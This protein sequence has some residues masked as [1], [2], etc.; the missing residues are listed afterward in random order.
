MKVL[1]VIAFALLATAT[2]LAYGGATAG[3]AS[4]FPGVVRP[5]EPG[6]LLV[7]GGVL[8]AA[9]SLVKRLRV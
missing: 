4:G 1:V 5:A 7:S 9:A 6:V 8:L 2:V 3:M